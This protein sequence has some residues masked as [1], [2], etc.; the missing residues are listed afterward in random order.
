MALS[1]M[2]DADFLPAETRKRVK[3]VI[4]AIRRAFPV[5]E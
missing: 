5:S 2:E 4:E 1:K 3:S